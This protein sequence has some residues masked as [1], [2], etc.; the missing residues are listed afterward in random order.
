MATFQASFPGAHAGSRRELRRSP[1]TARSP[2]GLRPHRTTHDEPPTRAHPLVRL[3]AAITG[4]GGRLATPPRGSPLARMR[5]AILAP[6]PLHF[7]P[8]P[9]TPFAI[10]RSDGVFSS[11]DAAQPG[12]SHP[13]TH[14][15]RLTP[16]PLAPQH[17]PSLLS[18]SFPLAFEPS[19][20]GPLGLESRSIPSR[21]APREIRA[22]CRLVR[23]RQETAAASPSLRNAPESFDTGHTIRQRIALMQIALRETIPRQRCAPNPARHST[24]AGVRSTTEAFHL[25]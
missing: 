17:P 25:S 20:A 8:T 1:S 6:T 3:H 11:T 7:F 13:A 19:A 9:R 18:L 22:R 15:R 24:R 14:F 23:P 16:P 4:K 10:P 5:Q 12:R 2:D 21:R